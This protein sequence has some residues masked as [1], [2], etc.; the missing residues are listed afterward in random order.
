M[1]CARAFGHGWRGN[2]TSATRPATVKLGLYS[3]HAAQQLFGLRDETDERVK[4]R[5]GD[6]K[7]EWKIFCPSL[8]ND[9][10]GAEWHVFPNYISDAICRV[11][12][13]TREVVTHL[14][15]C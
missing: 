5:R 12:S 8:L 15:V 6:S 9:V 11:Q 14:G 7:V 4:V 3:E 13:G 2:S 1:T 10:F